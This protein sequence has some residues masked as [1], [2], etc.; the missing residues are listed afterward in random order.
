MKGNVMEQ[1]RKGE[2]KKRTTVGDGEGEGEL[3]E[4]GF[5]QKPLLALSLKEK[6]DA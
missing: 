5:D 1:A 3:E 2:R 6:D 4:K